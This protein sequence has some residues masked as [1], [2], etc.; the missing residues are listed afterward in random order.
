MR[1]LDQEGIKVS[2]NRPTPVSTMSSP[3]EHIGCQSFA[4]EILDPNPQKTISIF[5][6]LEVS[7]TAY[8]TKNLITSMY[9]RGVTSGVF[10]SIGLQRLLVYMDTISPFK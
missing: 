9:P 4:K 8:G 6:P 3:C 2:E 7:S 5:T 1:Y 10:V